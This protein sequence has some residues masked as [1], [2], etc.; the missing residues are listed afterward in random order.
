MVVNTT[1]LAAFDEEKC[2]YCGRYGCTDRG[3]T[4]TAGDPPVV[5]GE[6]EMVRRLNDKLAEIIEDGKMINTLHY[7]NY[8]EK[9]CVRKLKKSNLQA[10]I[11]QMKACNAT[12]HK[13]MV[14]AED[15]IE[16]GIGKPRLENYQ[17]PFRNEQDSVCKRNIS[18]D[19]SPVVCHLEDEDSWE[20]E[21]HEEAYRHCFKRKDGAPCYD[22]YDKF[23]VVDKKKD[24]LLVLAHR[25]SAAPCC[26]CEEG[27]CKNENSLH[28]EGACTF[29]GL[30]A[31]CEQYVPVGNDHAYT[32]GVCTYV[33][34][35][36]GKDDRKIFNTSGY[37]ASLSKTQRFT[38]CKACR[39]SHSIANATGLK[40]L[41][42][43]RLANNPLFS[44]ENPLHDH[45]I[46]INYLYLTHP[47]DV[48]KYDPE[49]IA[50]AVY[51]GLT[52]NCYALK[53]EEYQTCKINTF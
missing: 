9:Q 22:F 23:G 43:R 35:A 8:D 10:I 52:K 40:C 16:A 50:T 5:L 29:K 4:M 27:T 14:W 44:K 7:V 45:V 41:G 30:M 47:E 24:Y 42:V 2:R 34:S 12:C 19:K 37:G 26:Y 6:A 11:E 21:F 49:V 32:E 46:Q 48:A 20:C 31:P 17:C 13:N 15:F 25:F 1:P 18:M 38:L 53:C 39:V 3:Y 28:N 33:S 51:D 36:D